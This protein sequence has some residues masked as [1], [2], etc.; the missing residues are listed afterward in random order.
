MRAT[1]EALCAH[2]LITWR[3]LGPAAALALFRALGGFEAAFSEPLSAVPDPLRSALRQCRSAARDPLPA[4]CTAPEVFLLALSDPDYPDLLREIPSPPPLLYG[5]GDP[6][7]LALPAIAVVGSRHASGAGLDTASRFA[8]ELAGAGFA[9]VSGL[10]LGIDAAAHRGALAAG[11][12]LAVTGTGIDRVYPRQ[13]ADLCAEILAGGGALVTEFPPGTPPRAGNFP[14][15]NRII[16]GLSLGVLVVEAAL[17]SGSLITAR[18]ALD[19]GR[20]VFAVPGSI[21]NPR[22]RGCHQLIREGAT[23]AETTADLVAQLGG[24]LAFKDAEAMPAAAT[25]GPPVG[26]EAERVL[27]A[28]GYDPLAVDTL[29]ERTGLDAAR[30]TRVLVELELSGRVE[31][32]G[33]TYQRLP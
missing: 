26:S 29:V 33:G 8:R 10:A 19:Q 9:V 21:H 5:R 14:R 12:T 16:S 28:M 25:A 15:R 18:Q 23:L 7:A 32:R 30:L 4:V 6:L 1:R 20:E 17:R 24:L 2:Q 27:E 3:G 13:H 31:N 11:R 22:A